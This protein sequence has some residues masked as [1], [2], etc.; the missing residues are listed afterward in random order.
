MPGLAIS[1]LLLSGGSAAFVGLPV[2]LE[3]RSPVTS[4]LAQRSPQHRQMPATSLR[5]A[6]IA[7][8]ESSGIDAL[9]PWFDGVALLNNK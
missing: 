9:G 1:S 4:H 3:T 2:R 5:A 6:S 7:M 8:N